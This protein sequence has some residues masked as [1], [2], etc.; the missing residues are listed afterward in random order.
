MVR[1]LESKETA[2]I[3]ANDQDY[4]IGFFTQ[5]GLIF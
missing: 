2:I 1:E 3:N 4:H 5:F